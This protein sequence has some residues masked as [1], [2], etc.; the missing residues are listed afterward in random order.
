LSEYQ[1]LKQFIDWLNIK[2]GNDVDNSYLDA[3]L[4]E[5][6]QL[7]EEISEIESVRRMLEAKIKAIKEEH[8][9]TETGLTYSQINSLSYLMGV[10]EEN[11]V[12]PETRL[13]RLH[14][15]LDGVK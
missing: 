10:Y 2:T 5:Y 12:T 8:K 13:S 7:N 15:D 1:T 9:S 14:A 11:F 6:L 3:M 4:R